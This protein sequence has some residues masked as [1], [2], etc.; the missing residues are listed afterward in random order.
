MC[1]SPANGLALWVQ[2]SEGKWEKPRVRLELQISLDEVERRCLE[3][4]DI[5]RTEEQVTVEKRDGSGKEQEDHLDNA[6]ENKVMWLVRKASEEMSVWEMEEKKGREE[7]DR[8]TVL[9]WAIFNH[10]AP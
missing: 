2:R 1:N 4:G 7:E 5:V 8:R 3:W 10:L 6:N 9:K